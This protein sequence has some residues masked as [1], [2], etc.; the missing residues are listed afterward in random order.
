GSCGFPCRLTR[1]GGVDPDSWSCPRTMVSA[2]DAWF[3]HDKQCTARPAA[4]ELE[5][6]A[7]RAFQSDAVSRAE[8]RSRFGNPAREG[9]MMLRTVG[10]LRLAILLQRCP[11]RSIRHQDALHLHHDAVARA[12]RM[13]RIVER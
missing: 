4:N 10:G 7:I 9:R 3:S 2:T 6:R 8:G 1:P 13:E 5:R 12:E 11:L